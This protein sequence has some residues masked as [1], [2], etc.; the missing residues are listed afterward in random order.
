[1]GK[2]HIWVKVFLATRFSF[3]GFSGFKPDPLPF[4]FRIID[5]LKQRR[6]FPQ[7]HVEV[8]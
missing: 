7:S 6:S 4:W 5:I 8:Q 3:F 2:N 1:M